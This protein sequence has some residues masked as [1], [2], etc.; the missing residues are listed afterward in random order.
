MLWNPNNK[1]YRNKIERQSAWKQMSDADFDNKFTDD[2][3]VAKWSNMRIQYRSYFAKYREKKSG[4]TIKWKYYEAMSFV[5]RAEEQQTST[6][7]SNLVC[8]HRIFVYG[9]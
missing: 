9:I 5:D 2:Q 1:K 6:T 4:D 3:L 7:V 8:I